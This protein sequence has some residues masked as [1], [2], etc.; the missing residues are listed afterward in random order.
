MRRHVFPCE[1]T[2][3]F[4]RIL[5]VNFHSKFGLEIPSNS[6]EFPV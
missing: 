4:L 2:L 5:G 3:E 6:L 1:I